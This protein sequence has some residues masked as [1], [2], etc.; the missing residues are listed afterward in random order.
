MKLIVSSY[1]KFYNSFKFQVVYVSKRFTK[2][3]FAKLIKSKNLPICS[4]DLA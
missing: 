2:K 3:I 4:A 1:K